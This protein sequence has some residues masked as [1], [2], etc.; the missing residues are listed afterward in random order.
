MPETVAALRERARKNPLHPLMPVI[1]VLFAGLS[2]KLGHPGW[3]T[4]GVLA[5]YPT[6]AAMLAAVR[7]ASHLLNRIACLACP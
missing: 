4:A 1:A 2:A 6:Y 3:G 5:L 7:R